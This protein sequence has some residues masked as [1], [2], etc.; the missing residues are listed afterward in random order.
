MKGWAR[1]LLKGC[2]KNTGGLFLGSQHLSVSYHL[3]PLGL[4]Q[5]PNLPNKVFLPGAFR[6]FL[7]GF[8]G[9]VSFFSD[10]KDFL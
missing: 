4:S 1:L 6:M 10:P 2:H 5:K 3:P 8:L 7:R 9:V